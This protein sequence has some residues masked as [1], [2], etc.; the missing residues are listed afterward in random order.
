MIF[1]RKFILTLTS[2]DISSVIPQYPVCGFSFPL[3]KFG[4]ILI[5]AENSL[6]SFLT[7]FVLVTCS[8]VLLAFLSQPKTF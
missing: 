3:A 4:V 8:P 7:K 1:V 6:P 2:S 5:F